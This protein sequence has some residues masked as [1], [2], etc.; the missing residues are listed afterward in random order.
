MRGEE[1]KDAHLVELD[2]L[3]EQVAED[4]V[5]VVAL[6]LRVEH[7]VHHEGEEARNA[8]QELLLPPTCGD[9][10]RISAHSRHEEKLNVVRTGG[11]GP[12]VHAGGD[13][14]AVVGGGRQRHHQLHQLQQQPLGPRQPWARKILDQI[15]R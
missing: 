2:E 13:P 4:L 6:L 5:R 12:L 1:E 15:F 14:V 10:R 9:T 8:A 3:G 7:L 11:L